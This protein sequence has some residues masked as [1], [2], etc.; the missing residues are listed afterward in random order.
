[1]RVRAIITEDFTN[2]KQP[3]MFIGCVDCDWKCCTDGGF[4]PSVCINDAW[5]HSSVQDIDNDRLIEKYLS[6][7]ITNAVV[8]GLLEPMLQFYEI[9]AF[10]AKLRLEYMCNDDVVIYTGYR[11]DELE[12]ELQILA[13]FS[14]IVVKFGRFVPNNEKHYDDVLGVELASDN[15]YAKRIS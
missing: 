5:H 14:N 13:L 7:P 3:A 12:N 1:M 9:V 6:N 10:I 11:E 2:Y 4:S 8:F 15:Q